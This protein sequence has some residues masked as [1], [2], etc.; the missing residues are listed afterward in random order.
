[1]I[2]CDSKPALQSL[3]SA[4]C[5][6]PHE[7]LLAEIRLLYDRATQAGH[8]I[9]F[10]WLPSHCGIVGNE[11][12]DAAARLAHQKT[13]TISIPLSR[14]DAARTLRKLARET[15]LSKW[16][17]QEFTSARIHALDPHLQ[18]P[19]PLGLPRSDATILCR[20]WLGV[21]FTNAYSYLIG[22]AASGTCEVCDTPETIRHVLC[23][24]HGFH[25]NAASSLRLHES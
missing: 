6:G 1:M 18:R 19:L 4:L 12:A 10:Q 14:T 25:P 17:T 22:M 3:Q 16:G 23:V 7:Q 24:V 2:F 13:E 5:R 15:T 20:L 11:N 9:A 21:A 8:D